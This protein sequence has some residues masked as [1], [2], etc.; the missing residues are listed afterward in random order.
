MSKPRNNWHPVPFRLSEEPEKFS[1]DITASYTYRGTEYGVGRVW[2]RLGNAPLKGCAVFA[3]PR[4][5]EI[6]KYVTTD[7]HAHK[8]LTEH[9]CPYAVASELLKALPEAELSSY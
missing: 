8:W 3:R 7:N 1:V 9:G 5:G 6:D 4:D 2:F